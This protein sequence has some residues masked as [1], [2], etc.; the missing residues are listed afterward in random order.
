[1]TLREEAIISTGLT[2]RRVAAL[3][4]LDKAEII[5]RKR[6]SRWQRFRIGARCLRAVRDA[7]Y[8][9]AERDA[10]LAGLSFPREI[11]TEGVVLL[12]CNGFYYR[13]FAR[14]MLLSFEKV[15]APQSVHL[16]ISGAD[17]ETVEDVRRLADKFHHLALSLTTDDASIAHSLPYQSVYFTALRFIVLHGVL[18][19]T[20]RPVLCL[21][22]DGIARKP[23]WPTVAA[24]LDGSDAAL[25]RR[26]EKQPWRK[27]RAGAAA[28]APT[29]Q[30]L[31][32]TD[33]LSRALLANLSKLPR[34]HVDQITLHHVSEAMTRK[35]GLTVAPL[36][37]S[38]SSPELDCDPLVWTAQSWRMKNSEE[39]QR[40]LRSIEETVQVPGQDE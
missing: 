6:H 20:G 25:I 11:A 32:F 37:T 27:V 15:A 39:Y 40:M 12:A 10:F 26:D 23:L 18:T 35:D 9:R 33:A 16:H 17:Q 36:T 5:Q 31:N 13:S 19:T 21:D 3:P 1:V 28:F 34:Y 8:F 14:G 30:G 2:K 22:V 38:L 7:A 29:R 24:A 4:T